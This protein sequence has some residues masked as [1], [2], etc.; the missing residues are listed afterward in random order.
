MEK[1]TLYA[2]PTDN[3]LEKEGH[4]RQARYRFLLLPLI[5]VLACVGA[6][7]QSNSDLTGIITD[8]TGA[9]VADATI[10]LTN[11]ATGS[12]RTT[13]SSATGLYDVAGLNPGNYDLRVSA[14]G[15]QS[16]VQTGVVVN[17]SMTFRVDVRLTIGAETQTVTVTADA[18]TVQADSNVLST[19]I[20]GQ[21][22][23]DIA[24]ENNNIA[25]I[26]S[27]GL[28]VSNN[29]PDS[30]PPI[31][32]NASYGISVNGLKPQHNVYLID[33]GEAYDRGSGGQMSIMPSMEGI[34]EFETL[35]SN[36]PPDYGISSGATISLSLKSGTQKFHG[37][38]FETNRNTDFDANYFF[39][40]HC[41]GTNCATPRPATHYNIYGGNIG[42]PLYIPGAYNRDKKK[43]FFFWNEEWRKII[44]G[45]GTN[46]QPALDK[47][48]L[49]GAGP[50]T[51]VAPA[52]SSGN[53]IHV[54]NMAATTDYAVNHLAPLGLVPGGCFNG[55]QPGGLGKACTDPQVIPH[56]LFDPNGALYINS[57]I[58]PTATPGLSGGNA[59]KNLSSNSVNTT[60]RDDMV[61]I[62]HNIN[63]KWQLLGHYLHDTAGG[64]N[65]LP[66]LGWLWASYN[67]IGSAYQNPANSAAI[68]ISGSI[69][70]NLLLEAVINYDGNKINIHNTPNPKA[71]PE[72]PAGWSVAPMIPSFAITRTAM[73]GIQ[74]FG[75][76]YWT[77]ED[78]STDPY[79]NATADYEPKLDISYTEGRHAMK[80]GFSYNRFT[81]RQNI[82]GDEQ[83]NYGMA[84]LSGDGI[85]DLLLG[86]AGSYNQEQAAPQRYYVNQTPSLYAMD[87]WHVTSRMSLQLGV[88]YDAYP[89]AWER[90]NNAS[91][92]DPEMF[93]PSMAPSSPANW[94]RGGTICDA[95]DAA[96]VGS[97][98]LGP[99][100]TSCTASG[101]ISTTSGVYSAPG[102]LSQFYLN[103]MGLAGRYGF[104]R[105]L[106]KNDYKTWQPRLGFSE[107]LFGNGKTILRGGFGIFYEREQ[108]NDIYNAASN[109][110][111]SNNPSLPN[112]YFSR[113]GSNW[114]TG[115][116][117]SAAQIPV[118]STGVTSLA[119][120]YK[121]PG[122]AQYSLGVQREVL[123]SVIWIVQYVGNF[124]WHQ[125]VDRNINTFPTT[126]GNLTANGL[127][128]SAANPAEPARCIA[129]DPHNYY[130]GDACGSNGFS[131]NGGAN[132]YVTYPGY[133]GINQEETTTNG[134]Y[135]GFQT[136]LRAQNKWGLS[137]EVDY[138]YSHEIDIQTSELNN[139]QISD[140]WNL[141]Y[142]K[143]SGALDRRQ[144]LS[145]NYVY[146]L[147][148]FTKSAG[149]A[150]DIVGGWEIAGTAIDMA[151]TPAIVT[152]QNYAPGSGNSIDPVGLNGGY[153]S[154]PNVGMKMHYPK[155]NLKSLTATSKW[156]ETGDFYNATPSWL[157]GPNMGFGNAGK[158]T[159]IGPRRVNFTTSLYKSFAWG[160]RMKVQLKFETFNTFNHTEFSGIGTSL[161][162][163][164]S[165][166]GFGQVNN[167]WDPRVLQLAGKFVF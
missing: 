21:Q 87:N 74:G 161:G 55:P 136:S 63:D 71:N 141:K 11:P 60:V 54:P 167:T 16:F 155:A 163:G 137:G 138:T 130:P 32:L 156:F 91:N 90:G 109:A 164:G 8:Q 107:D 139:G 103:G 3:K 62:D 113:P 50:L 7:A 58:I 17:V 166:N 165:D 102:V 135:N 92:F 15:F 128:A 133:G 69:T 151:G 108:G 38:L 18:L 53:T 127:P 48:D 147:P 131:S 79:S 42:G 149:L 105:G 86:L 154:R 95:T 26:V 46:I 126:I 117:V 125:S 77:A 1:R 75:G 24:V 72:K 101:G 158:D 142:D 144:M 43:T 30:N 41:A 67:T 40:K 122:D 129:G 65:N 110:P 64:T 84:T 31:A 111:F 57:G 120:V 85:M 47:G 80:F 10:T 106:V 152:T 19:L 134:N 153:T 162:R 51:Y 157:G 14:K 143:G 39:A 68:K 121:A 98:S 118:F 88:R 25:S 112:V 35:A 29:M 52:F 33:G 76:P 78:T 148:I 96:T 123:P 27:L 100:P 23:T 132:P 159:V 150:H 4:M 56:S 99:P 115:G 73:P 2:I 59:G 66:L 81:K 36:Y 49:P 34:A 145:I 119:H 5:F 93:N 13:V 12:E 45:A 146:K 160:E 44:T 20:S 37:T 6:F 104:P 22:I 114:Q 89:H 70:P 82:G 9:V 83:G 94:T 124:S 61:R 140:P 28:G 116:V 97:S